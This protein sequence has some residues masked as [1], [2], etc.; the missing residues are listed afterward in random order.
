MRELFR[1]ADDHSPSIVF[2]DE[3]DAVGVSAMTPLPEALVRFRE[4]CLNC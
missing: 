2:I 3:V 4:P 1:V